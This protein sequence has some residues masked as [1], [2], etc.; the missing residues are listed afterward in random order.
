MARAAYDDEGVPIPGPNQ[1]AVV[2]PRV[3]FVTRKLGSAARE[4]WV[5]A[6]DPSA[7]ASPHHAGHDAFIVRLPVG[8]GRLPVTG[9]PP[10]SAADRLRKA[11]QAHDPGTQVAVPEGSPVSGLYLTSIDGVSGYVSG[12]GR[13]FIVGDMLDLVSRNNVTE[14]QRQAKRR[15]LLE[16]VA[17]NEGIL[18]APTKP[19]HTI[20]VF[21]D[22]DCPY[23][24]KLHGELPQLEARGI[25]VRYIAFPRS[26]PNTK[27]WRTMAAV[28]CS[29]D[30]ARCAD[31]C[32]GWR[33]RDC[34]RVMQRR[35][36]RQAL[37]ARATARNSRHADDRPEG[38]HFARRLYA[39]RQAPYRPRDARRR[40]R[41][42]AATVSGGRE[43]TTP[44]YR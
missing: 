26:G 10:D 42:R 5:V 44:V 40:W 19:E 2:R 3:T 28:W 25:A 30:R 41:G 33:S 16:Q 20:I 6:A 4:K 1:P 32:D 37:R 14:Q 39:T 35:S 21:T 43:P 11:I 29:S 9:A 17:P 27:S 38:R 8:D 18:F 15:A 34:C 24:R 13:Y 31:S 36:H 12:D 7:M 23:C 22:A